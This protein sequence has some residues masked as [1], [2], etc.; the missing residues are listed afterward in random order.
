MKNIVK[1]DVS[2]IKEQTIIGRTWR[3]MVYG[4]Y[5]VTITVIY[6]K[7]QSIPASRKCLLCNDH[8]GKRLNKYDHSFC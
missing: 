6:I 3:A 1:V 4:D 7:S 5:Y 8:R 2:Q